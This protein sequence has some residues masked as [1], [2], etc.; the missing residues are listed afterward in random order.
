MASPVAIEKPK[1]EEL[2]LT[3]DAVDQLRA[4]D[5]ELAKYAQTDDQKAAIKSRLLAIYQSQ[6]ITVSDEILQ[7]GIEAHFNNR[8]IY[9]PLTGLPRSLALA[10]INRKKTGLTAGLAACSI[11]FLVLACW[12]FA[13]LP[14]QTLQR[15]KFELTQRLDSDRKRVTQ[16]IEPLNTIQLNVKA[17]IAAGKINEAKSQI[18]NLEKYIILLPKQINFRIVDKP[19]TKSGVVWKSR[20][21]PSAKDYYLIVE[22]L[23]PENNPVQ[24]PITDRIT[25]KSV[26]TNMFGVN[27]PEAVFEHY[28]AE[29]IRTGLIHNPVIGQKPANQFNFQFNTT[30]NNAYINAW[31]SR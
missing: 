2:L 1:F 30:T 24:I 23:D 11:L 10:W 7:Q 8:F 6:G 31:S 28:R 26:W 15:E 4:K 17:S 19:G 22:A 14:G 5:T 3:M 27:V 20:N 12:A 9:K 25:Q 29:K 13:I 18:A 16:N 21:V